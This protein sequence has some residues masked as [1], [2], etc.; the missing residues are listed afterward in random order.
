MSSNLALDIIK[1]YGR[2]VDILYR[3]HSIHS[4]PLNTSDIQR[5]T[6]RALISLNW[7]ICLEHCTDIRSKF[8][9]NL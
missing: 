9:L 2:N 1:Q 3:Q 4:Q 7:S 5:L 6:T 8:Q